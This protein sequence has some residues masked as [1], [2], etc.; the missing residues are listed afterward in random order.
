MPLI[1]IRVSTRKREILVDITERVQA[2]RRRGRTRTRAAWSSIFVPHTTAGVTINEGADPSVV[3]DIVEG[4]R[5]LVPREAGYR[6]GEGNSDAHIKASLIGSSVLV[7]VE[8]G[9]AAA[10][11]LAEHL[12]GRVRRSAEPAGL[13]HADAGDDEEATHDRPDE[14]QTSGG[15]RRDGTGPPVRAGPRRLHRRSRPATTSARAATDPAWDDFLLGFAGG[16]DPLYEDLKKHVGP[17]ALDPG[18]GLRRRPGRRAGDRHESR[19]AAGPPSRGAADAAAPGDLTVISWALCQTES[20][21]GGQPPRDPHAVRALGPRPHLR[22]AGATARCTWPWSRRSRGQGYEAVAPGAAARLGARPIRS[23]NGW[24]STWSERHVAYVCGLG[25]FGLSGGL[26][27]EQGPGGAIRLGHRQGASSPPPRAPT[28][29]PSPTACTSAEAT[30][31]CA[32]TAARWARSASRAGTRKPAP[33][34]SNP[35]SDEYVKTPLRLRRLRLRPLPDRRCPA[36]P[37]SPRG[38]REP[39]ARPATGAEAPAGALS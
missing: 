14:H 1:E 6:H 21:Q 39:K 9:T 12:S 7:P 31:P 22:A 4:L 28:T 11:H 29:V 16:D 8:R 35:R 5:R 25:T 27:T 10:R 3:R 19:R 13:D 34:T 23:T 32:P 24:R 20:R 18:R 30:A 15:R 37:A 26:I 33:T 17:A 38:R 36:N 2:R